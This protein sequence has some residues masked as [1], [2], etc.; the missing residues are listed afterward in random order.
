MT[1][2]YTNYLNSSYVPQLS[3]E[4]EFENISKYCRR[5]ELGMNW[6]RHACMQLFAKSN[7][8]DMSVVT[9]NSNSSPV[10]KLTA[11]YR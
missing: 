2:L 10:S 3:I 7:W 8:G 1:L 5:K 6:R 4:M 9:S 11:V